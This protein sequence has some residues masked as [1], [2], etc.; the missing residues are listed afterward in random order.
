MFPTV[1][2]EWKNMKEGRNGDINI[3]TINN[4]N[5]NYQQSKNDLM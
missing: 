2:S 4:E 3:R 5:W 1:K